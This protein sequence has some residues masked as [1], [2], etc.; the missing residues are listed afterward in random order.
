[1][2]QVGLILGTAAYMSPEQAKGKAVDKRADIW[3]FG[4]VLFEMLTG[5][6]PF[7][8]E[9]VSDVLALGARARATV[10][11]HSRRVPA[12]VRQVLKACLQKDP[13][14]RI[15]DMADVRLAMAGVF[16]TVRDARVP[17]RF[18]GVRSGRSRRS[19]GGRPRGR[20]ARRRRG[21]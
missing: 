4:V 11:G 10:G 9:E 17:G 15:H 2:T 5:H 13:K 1:M 21:C 12:I 18:L 6:R 19:R 20:V 8:G 14:K 3:A 7:A 16:E